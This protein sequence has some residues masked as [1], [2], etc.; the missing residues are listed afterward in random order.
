MSRSKVRRGFCA[1]FLLGPCAGW[2][3]VSGI[4]R[5]EEHIPGRHVDHFGRVVQE[6]CP[7]ELSPGFARCYGRWIVPQSVTPDATLPGLGGDQIPGVYGVPSTAKSGGAI[8]AVVDAGGDTSALTDLQ[9][10]RTQYGLGSIAKCASS[11][12]TAGGGACLA[13]V[14]QTGGTSLPANDRNWAAETSLDLDMVSASCPDC[15]IVLVEASSQNNAD[16]DAAVDYAASVPGVVAISNSYGWPETGQQTPFRMSDASHFNHAGIAILAASGDQDYL[17]QGEGGTGPSFPASA[18][19]VIGV[20]GTL[21]SP[22]TGGTR[23]WTETVW[24][25]GVVM[26]G[27]EGGGSGCSAFYP[28]PAW[29]TGISTGSCSSS[30]RASV[31]VSAAADYM[32]SSGGGGIIVYCGSGC[33]AGMSGFAQVLGTSAS[34][35]I[36]AGILARL[37]IASK[38]GANPGLLY[39]NPSAF[40]DVA[41]GSNNDPSGQCSDVM[42]TAGP[43]WD[44]PT[45][46]GTPNGEALAALGGSSSSS[47]GSSGGGGSTSSSGG[48]SGSSSG[49]TTGSGSGAGSGGSS[50]G[51]PSS[52]SGGSSGAVSSASSGGSK[53]GSSSSSGSSGGKGPSSRDGGALAVAD[54]GSNNDDGYFP[55]QSS[56]CSCTSAVGGTSFPSDPLGVLGV[57]GGLGFVW[58]RSR[59][60][61]SN[62]RA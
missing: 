54:A 8:V 35:P 12:P 57:A 56:G 52:G 36:V 28:R 61:A 59:K 15:S 21:L 41:D 17:D 51:G 37:G 55:P 14:N 3:G 39:S 53:G 38:V 29:Q 45:G 50:S 26:T 44:G 20:G 1:A 48:S 13:I 10:Y 46:L 22:A 7:A 19:T 23:A 30:M 2:I 9:K 42:C 18:P 40:F 6:M 43:G 34:T 62:V 27:A 33:G 31:D 49:G 16:L 25:D 32:D 5:A 60:R 24:N 4:A 11:L 47:G 58:R